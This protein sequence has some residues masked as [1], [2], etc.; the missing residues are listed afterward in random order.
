[1]GLTG[2]LLRAGA[3]RPHVLTVTAPGATA[4]RLAAEEQLRRRGWP[5]ALSPADADILLTCGDFA[6]RMA[7]A[8]TET[9]QAMPAPRA[10]RAAVRP[11]EV[12][13]ALDAARAAVADLAGQRVLAA[14]TAGRGVA[15]DSPP[16]G[17]DMSEAPAGHMGMDMPAMDMG[18]MHGMSMDMDGTPGMHMGGTGEMDMGGMVV[19]GTAMARRGP[20]RDGLRLDQL[21]LPLG[22]VL[23]DW[24]A[25][26][27]L[28]LTLQGDVIQEAEAEA[29]AAG[30]GSFW[31]E[32]WRRAAA[33]QR[34]TTAEASR[35]RAAAHLDSLARLLGV[36][37]W[38]A[39]ATAA[40]RL[41]DDV[42]AGK[43][44]SGVRRDARRLT[45]RVGRSRL[46][47]WLTSGL[48][49]L[50]AAHAAAAG[51]AGPV[52]AGGDVTARYRH[53]C[54]EIDDAM[55]VLE[56]TSPLR[57]AEFGPP[58]GWAAAGGP[59]G[60]GDVPTGLLTVLPRLL[61]GTEFAGA[62]LVIASLD[63]DLDQLPARAGTAH[64]H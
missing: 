25:G 6:G 54:A 35:R 22:P 27:L 2:L 26:L 42:L 60:T 41:R 39:A 29:L 7:A 3:A 21:H 20:D 19:H 56:D 51:M 10:R 13:P 36:A 16:D 38:E 63:P 61:A 15:R 11:A 9:W 37:G 49:V 43:P 28:R 14:E 8:V 24:P 40:R 31:D 23:P 34:V 47:A 33:G 58:R 64:G 44:R 1:M 32:P 12:A 57:P 50:D 46:L 48:G 45:R 4:V 30:D 59:P 62:R 55:T 53:W 17:M 18:G 52:A 5:E